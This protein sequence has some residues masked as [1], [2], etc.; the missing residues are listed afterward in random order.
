MSTSLY[1]HVA[2]RR[3]AAP[4][5]GLAK[6]AAAAVLGLAQLVVFWLA[7][8]PNVSEE[9]RAH[10]IDHTQT[11]WI[12]RSQL[13][14]NHFA[15]LPRSQ[16]ASGLNF[17]TACAVLPSGWW[18]VEGWGI[19][20]L[21]AVSHMRVPYDAATKTLS[22][23]LKAPEFLPAPQR[24]L[25]RVDNLPP[26]EVEI[27]PGAIRDVPLPRPAPL[28]GVARIEIDVPHPLAPKQVGQSD[29]ERQ[30]GIGLVRIDH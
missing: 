14:Q 30:I 27:P 19:W 9:Y 7:F 1:D 29:D 12:P 21:G 25:I 6:L 15:D 20:S 17:A 8:H 22:L 24:V 5:A 3:E 18:P 28:S 11:C 23:T 26:V 13:A 16:S 2:P 10:Y 4:R